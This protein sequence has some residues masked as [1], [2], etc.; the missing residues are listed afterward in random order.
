V[1]VDRY[2]RVVFNLALRMVRSYDDA[3]EIAQTVFV[4]A[5][6]KIASFNP[7]HRFFSWIYRMTINESINHLK[8]ARARVPLSESQPFEG[9]SA[10]AVVYTTEVSTLLDEAMSTLS[11]EYRTILVLRHIGELSYSEL[12]ETLLIPV[13]TVKSRLFTARKLLC[14]K[15]ANRGVTYED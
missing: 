9:K 8:R 11:L 2:Q 7:E 6:E 12:S 5:F 10:E 4:K 15:L 1:L 13:K 3:E 14:A